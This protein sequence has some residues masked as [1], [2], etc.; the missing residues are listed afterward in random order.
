MGNRRT[1]HLFDK[2][3]YIKEVVPIVRN[4]ESY[5][6]AFLNEERLRWLG[7]FSH[8]IDNVLN[9]TIKF[10]SELNEELNI[11]I[12]LIKINERKND[13]NYDCF[14]K[15]KR[16]EFEGFIRLR[17]CSIE[18]FE[19]LL[20]ETIFSTVVGFNPHFILGKNLFESYIETKK[21]SISEELTFRITTQHQGAILDLID[22]GIINWLSKEEVELLY[23][24]RD[25]ISHSNEESI[26]YVNEF[27]EF[28][29]M[30]FE[31]NLGLISLR[32]PREYDLC[33]LQNNSNSIEN[34][35]RNSNFKY[36]I[37]NGN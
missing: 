24:D 23:L 6:P 14:T 18:F 11:H 21:N 9:D 25:N 30:A 26:D 22:G 36:I 34:F 28:L 2:S 37:I 12:E 1:L 4:L 16:E 20:I 19:Y 32:N 17:Q 15:R 7:G 33:K 29:K 31:R 3:K 8:P 5:L 10:V 27:K 35:V 13:E